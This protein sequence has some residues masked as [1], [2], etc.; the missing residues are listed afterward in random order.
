MKPTKKRAVAASAIQ[1]VPQLW[2]EARSGRYGHPAWS[3]SVTPHRETPIRARRSGPSLSVGA[4][5]RTPPGFIAFGPKL[6]FSTKRGQAA[7][8][9]WPLE[10]GSPGA[11]LG[12]HPCVALPS[13][14]GAG[15]LIL[16]TPEAT[17]DGSASLAPRR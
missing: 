7:H 9:P 5:P 14:Q 8:A 10:L 15:K 2:V 12:S 3:L 13:A 1:G 16:T 4:P 6:A 11:A 17:T